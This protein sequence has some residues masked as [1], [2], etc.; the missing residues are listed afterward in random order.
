MSHYLG[1]RVEPKSNVMHVL[2]SFKVQFV[3]AGMKLPPRET[4]GCHTHCQSAQS[5]EID[6]VDGDGPIRCTCGL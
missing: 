5:H 6:Q 2:I 3:S 1:F 4:S